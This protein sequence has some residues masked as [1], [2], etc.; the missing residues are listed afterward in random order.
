MIIDLG[1]DMEQCV[2]VTYAKDGMA[3][4]VLQR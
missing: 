4:G 1:V 3:T 2:F